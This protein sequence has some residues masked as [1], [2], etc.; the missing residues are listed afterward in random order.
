MPPSL[1]SSAEMRRDFCCVSSEP[2]RP[3]YLKDNS[4][5]IKEAFLPRLDRGN[6]SRGR[7][8][9]ESLE[10]M[11]ERRFVYIERLLQNQG[12]LAFGGSWRVPPR[13]IFDKS[14]S[15][16]TDRPSLC[17]SARADLYFVCAQPVVE[18]QRNTC[19]CGGV[20]Q[21]EGRTHPDE[22]RRRV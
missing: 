19:M 7:Q 11:P 13:R 9:E 2:V 15:L 5:R 21:Y 22:A 10:G 12:A 4:L 1:S 16:R 14:V 6:S 20:G 8:G 3:H 18:K 17:D